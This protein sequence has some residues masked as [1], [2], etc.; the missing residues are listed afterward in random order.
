MAKKKAA[1]LRRTTASRT[2]A[3]KPAAPASA[4][5]KTALQEP[6]AGTAITAAVPPLA[7]GEAYAGI[8]LN[9]EGRPS[10]H[11]VLLPGDADKVTWEE[12]KA[13]AAKAGGELPTRKEQ[14]LLF[15]NAAQHFKP[16]WYWS[17]DPL[18]GNAEYAWDQYFSDGGQNGWRK[19][20]RTRARAV[21][22]VT[23]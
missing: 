19:G 10:H 21:R 18:A 3:R 12:A 6:A 16:T 2:R 14:A 1:A 22:R 20:S 13:F 8:L 23:I 17:S 5:A 15:A 11:L 7:K 9:A 4:Q